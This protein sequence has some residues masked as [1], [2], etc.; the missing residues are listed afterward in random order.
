MGKFDPGNWVLKDVRLF[1]V[2]EDYAQ[3]VQPIASFLSVQQFW[4][5]Y[6][7]IKRP[8]GFFLKNNLIKNDFLDIN[9]KVDFH[10]FKKGIKPVWEDS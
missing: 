7:H 5:T 4:D 2:L 6:R 10:L 9:E 3:Y 8:S 1:R